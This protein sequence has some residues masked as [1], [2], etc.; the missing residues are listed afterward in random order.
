MATCNQR[1]WAGTVS[2]I[3][4]LAALVAFMPG[5]VSMLSGPQE[6]SLSSTPPGAVVL[7]DGNLSYSTPASIYLDTRRAHTFEFDADGYLPQRIEIEPR[8]NVWRTA[9]GWGLDVYTYFIGFIVDW[10][11]GTLVARKFDQST[12]HA[13]L[14]PEASEPPPRKPRRPGRD[15][16][17]PPDPDI[18]RVDKVPPEIRILKPEVSGGAR[19]LAVVAVPAVTIEGLVTDDSGVA[20]VRING[21]VAELGPVPV[22]Y[23]SLAGPGTRFF[24]FDLRLDAAESEVHVSARDTAGN[25]TSF[26]VRI[27]RKSE[28]EATTVADTGP[29]YGRSIAAV[30]GIDDYEVWPPLSAAVADARSVADYFRGQGFDEVIEILDRDATRESILSL[31]GTELPK[32]TGKDDR[33]VI[34]FAGHG[35][36]ESLPTGDQQGYIIPADGKMGEFFASAIS[37]DQVRQLS[38]RIPARHILY[39][40]DS[41]Y[42]GMGF[43]R[44][45]GVDPTTPGYIRKVTSLKAVQM[46]A[47]GGAGEQ[48]QESEGHGVFT[49]LLLQALD[50][51]ADLDRDGFVTATELGAYLRPN[52]SRA[53]SQA[54]TPQY[55]RLVG[56]GEVVFRVRQ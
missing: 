34:Y 52:V 29:L 11:R 2:K 41:C 15:S 14:Q 1:R 44:S 46:I 37:M 8:V 21:R 55:G 10:R 27:N 36:T 47:A 45:A 12:I 32:R 13:E 9:L 51:D 49:R 17:R 19:G 4:L 25:E 16:E 23:R 6:M 7:V 5:C 20:D 54:Q 28:A 26:L 18:A 24:E 33:V 40:M 53:T 43:T 35:Q 31:L 39:I 22:E 56:E 30:I 48:A 3:S 38:K 42:S 50:G